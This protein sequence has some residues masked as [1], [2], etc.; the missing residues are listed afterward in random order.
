[1]EDF[2]RKIQLSEFAI[3]IYMKVLGKFLYS[4][5]ELYSI[6]PKATIDQFNTSLNELIEAG[7]LIKVSSK[8]HDM[9]TLYSALPP[10]LPILNYYENINASLP[11]IEKSIQ[12]L[13]SN[14]VNR[15]FQENKIIELDTVLNAFQ[16]IK[17]D[18]NEDSIIQKQEVEDIVEGMEKLKDVK[19]KVS[20]LQKDIKSITK[21]NFA[22]LTDTINN[23]KEEL[24][25]SIKKKEIVAHI[26]ELFKTKFEN[27]VLDITDNLYNLIE[28][29]F[30]EILKPIENI[31]DLIFQYRNDFKMLLLTMLTNFETNLIKI[32]ELLKENDDKI[33][34]AINNV[35]NKIAKSMNVI[36]QNS[37]NEISSLNAPIEDVMKNYLQTIGTIQNNIINNVWIITSING[38]NEAIQNL[39]ANSKENL[40]I[41]IPH[42]ENHIAFEQFDKVNSNL[43]IKITSSEAHTNSIVKSF[44]NI[45]NIL[46]RTSQNENLIILKGDDQQL[47][48]GIIKE[49]G[50]PLD[51]FIGFGCSFKPLIELFDP[52]INNIWEKAYP[53]TYHAAQV[54]KPEF[55][56]TTPAKVLTTAKPIID[57]KIRSETFEQKSIK[58]SAKD[59]TT[60][61]TYSNGFQDMT[62]ND[63]RILTS[64]PKEI[65]PSIAPK[66]QIKDLKQKL[67]EKIDFISDAQP[68]KDDEAAIEINN[69][70][71]NLILKLNTLKGD[72]FG[73]ELQ[74]I[75]DL[76]L[77]KKGF[78]VTLHKI[79]S[80]INK[81]KEKYT[82]LD[83]NDKREILEN[84]E[85]WKK[86]LY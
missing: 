79:R 55:S 16:E 72:Q 26:Q 1:M 50:K 64:Q 52:L 65:E 74:N 13:M 67:K 44:T 19:K 6:I 28:K 39:I 75:A 84:I 73:E 85:N 47:F 31:T 56:K 60:P 62:K 8:R 42:I 43:K 45:K 32:Y 40:T 7:L 63:K 35:E 41:I 78:S 86:K 17:K 76:I 51:D 38:I 59:K 9:V 48:L 20:E 29:K 49:L 54:V 77:E 30:D 14:S 5:Y 4:Y 82:L 2:L 61:R 27:K 33:S 53:D 83:A 46:Y 11:N 68:S 69:A 81:F 34:N 12:K 3:K 25:E 21:T 58:F 71:S 15:T 36:V 24:K 22:D 80:I 57:M 10:V 70:F 23:I 37:I 18:I 66:P